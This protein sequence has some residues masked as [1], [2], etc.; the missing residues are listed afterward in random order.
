MKEL[1]TLYILRSNL[2]ELVQLKKENQLDSNIIA[3]LIPEYQS[4]IDK[5]IKA[6]RF[7]YHAESGVAIDMLTSLVELKK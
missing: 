7:K 1:K 3:N 4:I 6:D 2:N 5:W